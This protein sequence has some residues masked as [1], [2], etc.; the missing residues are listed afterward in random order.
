MGRRRSPPQHSMDLLSQATILFG[1]A[2]HS[3]VISQAA[4]LIQPGNGGTSCHPIVI[5]FDSTALLT[6]TF[7]GG[8]ETQR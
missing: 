3:R 8:N 1:C 2:E 5:N 6:N 4:P 7:W